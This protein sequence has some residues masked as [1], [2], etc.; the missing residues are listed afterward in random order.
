[1]AYNKLQ[2]IVFQSD[3]YFSLAAFKVSMKKL[4][5]LKRWSIWR[6][7]KMMTPLGADRDLNQSLNRYYILDI[8]IILLS[9]TQASGRK[10]DYK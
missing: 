10:H 1:M 7:K 6:C 3:S 9:Y 4:T 8:I 2:L 5:E